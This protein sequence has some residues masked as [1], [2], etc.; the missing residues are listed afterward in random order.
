MRLNICILPSSIH[1]QCFA[2]LAEGIEWALKDLGHE[3]TREPAE[4]PK[5]RNIVFGVRPGDAVRHDTV[6]YNGEQVSDRSMWAQLVSLY[7]RHTVWDYSRKNANCYKQWGLPVP[8]VVRP[9]Y[10]PVLD[11]RIEDKPKTHDVVFVGSTNARRTALLEHLQRQGVS[12]LWVPFGTYGEERDELLGR[13]KLCLNIHFY[14]EAAIFESVRCSYLAQNGLPVVSEESAGNEEKLWGIS[15]VHYDKLAETVLRLLAHP[16]ELAQLC[17]VQQ[18]A[19]RQVLM[20]EEL[21]SA[22][23]QLVLT[24]STRKILREDAYVDDEP[25]TAIKGKK[26]ITVED[27][28][29]LHLTLSMIVK[30]EATI[31]ERCLA[32]VKPLLSSWCIVDTGSTDGTQDIIRKFMAD[33]P[34]SLHECSWKE[35]DGSRTEALDLARKEC[36]GEGWLLLIDADEILT[37]D[38]VLEIPT[39]HDAY[40]AWIRRCLGPGCKPWGRTT[41]LRAS[42]PWFYQLPRHEGIYCREFAPSRM[43]PLDN[44]LI[45]STK[46]GSR[47]RQDGFE[48]FTEDARVLEEWLVRNPDHPER[49]RAQYYL[50]QSYRDA[51]TERVPLDRPS[52]LKAAQAYLKRASMGAYDQEVHSSLLW[53]ADGMKKLDYP[54]EQIQQRWLEAFNQR[55]SRAEA[56]F[57]IGEHYRKM[58]KYPLAELF[59]RQAAALPMP[60]DI[61]PDVERSIYEWRAKEE[62]GVALTWLGRWREARELWRQVLACDL[63]P[64]DR[65]RIE[66]NLAESLKRAPEQPPI[67]FFGGLGEKP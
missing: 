7:S 61:F 64:H 28:P 48:R 44:V 46:D 45:L 25:V 51:S 17:I 62:L 34:G 54:W 60:G 14:P 29:R 66:Q 27:K 3:V 65:A 56:L 19:A 33:L 63:H 49:G 58:G 16:E 6:I 23:G 41:F 38:G 47:A 21:A 67:P 36:G 55:P 50:A 57:F 20:R 10:A 15:G 24:G 52:M 8:P 11:G 43:A 22:L 2:E 32:S 18:A 1:T 59:L 37:V 53:A 12:V 13:A 39:T 26:A 31:I 5:A 30:D 4:H 35:Y 40:N 9:G 42:K